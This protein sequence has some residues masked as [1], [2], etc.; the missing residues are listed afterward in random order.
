MRVSPSSIFDCTSSR[1]G[2]GTSSTSWGFGMLDFGA[3]L[4]VVLSPFDV[5][6][7]FSAFLIL[8]NVTRKFVYFCACLA[9]RYSSSLCRRSS[10][11]LVEILLVFSLSG[12]IFCQ[13]AHCPP[14]TDCK[15]TGVPPLTKG[16]RPQLSD[17]FGAADFA[18][19]CKKST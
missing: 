8:S 19:H 4:W 13:F 2:I 12:A 18:N 5:T 16:P 14:N 15:L 6:L 10:A 1:V 9:L 7:R 17:D 3:F 11:L